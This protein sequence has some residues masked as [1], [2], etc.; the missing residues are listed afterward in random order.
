MRTLKIGK[1]GDVFV[2]GES[3]DMSKLDKKSEFISSLLTLDLELDD[4]VSVGDMV[5][6]FYNSKAIIKDVLSEDYEVAR[7]LISTIELPIDYSHL[8]VY[9]SFVIETE[10]EGE[11]LYLLP[12]IELIPSEEGEAGVRKLSE[13]NVV[14]DE[15]VS[16]ESHNSKNDKFKMTSKTKISLMDV[17][18][19]LF[20]D[21][22]SVLK[23]GSILYK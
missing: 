12:E 23:E 11:F 9:K 6:F 17:M 19:C 20:E 8:R 21:L 4:S 1:E 7:A 22:V 3:A 14:I 13:L 2:N 18:T 15:N 16:L 10:G 5:H